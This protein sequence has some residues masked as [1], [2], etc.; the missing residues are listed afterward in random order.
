MRFGY[1]GA[2][3][4]GLEADTSN[5]YFDFDPSK[6]IACSRCVRACEEIQ[7]VGVLEMAQR[8]E[9]AEIIVGADGNPEHAGCT[10]CGECVR[11]CPTGAIHDTF[12]APPTHYGDDWP[13][14]PAV[15]QV[16][17]TPL[18]P[19]PGLDRRGG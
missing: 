11:V 3:H 15:C 4:L 5:P 19:P 1:E 10:W 7:V 9:H 14:L 18:P 16:A 17:L 13:G 8:G 12:R 6:C 2:N